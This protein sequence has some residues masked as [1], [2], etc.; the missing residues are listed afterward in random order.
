VLVLSV[1]ST[2]DLRMWAL[3]PFLSGGH[4]TAPKQV[5]RFVLKVRYDRS[6]LDSYS[7]RGHK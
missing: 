3:A 7:L 6:P 1:P 2:L 5:K 4:H